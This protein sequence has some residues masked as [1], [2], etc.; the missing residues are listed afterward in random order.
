MRF[1]GFVEDLETIFRS[2]R[3]GIVAER[4]GGGF[5]LKTLDYI[6]N[7]SAYCGD[8]RQHCR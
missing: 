8:K 6:F 7:P 3:I 4:I 5:K 2:V 1:L